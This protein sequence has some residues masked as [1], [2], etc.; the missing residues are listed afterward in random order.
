MKIVQALALTSAAVALCA[1]IPAMA[2]GG[3][4]GYTGHGGPKEWGTLDPAFSTCK[5][6][7]HQSP[8]DIHGAKAADLPAIQFDYKPS[9]LKV[10]DNGHTIQVNYAPG[11]TI[12]VGGSKYELLQF[13]FHHPSEEKVNG[14][15][16][17]MV[18]HLVHRNA[19]GKLAVVAVLLDKGGNSD[20]IDA[21]WKNLPKEKEKEVAVE[22]VTID[23]AK[24]L[25]ANRGYYA[26]EG[27][28][29][30]PPCSEDVRWLVLKSPVKIASAQ[31][32]AFGKLYPM[33]ARPTQPLNGRSLQA[34][35]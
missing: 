3:H 29:T 6:G 2:E 27:S 4:W 23:V 10:I 13:H 17:A 34:S 7:K 32:A 11:S 1:A 5:L 21:I 31:V 30:T 12:D 20:V 28:L 24:L 19:E 22:G 35:K 33:N 25:P 18:A 16:H 9:A 8:I 15:P 14:K 26:F